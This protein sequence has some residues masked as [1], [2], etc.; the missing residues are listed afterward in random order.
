[1]RVVLRPMYSTVPSCSPTMMKSPIT[2]GLS[3]AM[4]SEAKMSPR[5]FCTA[6]ATAMPPMPRL[7][8]SV[9]MLNPRLSRIISRRTA[10]S[11]TR[12]MK[13]STDTVVALAASVSL[14]RFR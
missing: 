4:D 1:M 12:A 9:V 14:C 3:M 11:A 2:N 6:S 13:P 7:A 5:M 10:H 8:T